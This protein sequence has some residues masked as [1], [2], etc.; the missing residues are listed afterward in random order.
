MGQTPMRAVQASALVSLRR[1]FF[2]NGQVPD[3]GL[4]APVLRSW[5]R[6]LRLGLDIGE[7]VRPSNTTRGDLM[8][9]RERN[10]ELLNHA[11]GVMEHLHEQIRASGSMVLLADAS[12]LILH[13]IGDPAFVD[14]A[15]RVALQPGASWS[16]C[17][18]GTNAIGATLIE[19]APVEVFGAEHYLDCNG[20]LT[21]SAAPILDCRGELLGALDIS[22]DHRNHQPHTLGLARM[23]VRLVERRMFESEYARHAIFAFHP[24]PEGVGGLQEGLLAVDADGEIVAADRQARALL[25]V[26]PGRS[27][28]LGGFGNLFRSSFGTV[29]G[30]AAR[31]P[32]ALMALELR[33]G[34][35]V[36]ARV[37]VSL[38]WHIGLQAAQAGGGARAART[39][40]PS[41]SARKRV[42]L[43]TLATGDAGLQFALDRCAKVVGRNIPILIQGESGSGKELLARACHNSGPRADGPFVAVNCAA[44]PEN[45]IE[46]ELFGY[47]GG[48]FTGARKEGAIGRIQQA[49]GG[50]L[51]LDEIGDMPLAMQARLLRVLQERCVQPVGAA[52]PVAVDIALLCATHRVLSDS[53]KAGCFREDLYYRVNGL[54][55][56]LPPLRERS[57]LHQIVR[58]LLDGSHHHPEPARIRIDPATMAVLEAYA[59]PGNIR[60]LQNV[61]EVALALLDEDEDCILPLHLPDEVL[62]GAEGAPVPRQ[63]ACA[64][65]VTQAEGLARGRGRRPKDID[66]AA[67]RAALERFDG[68]LSAAAR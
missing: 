16:E 2:D 54:T 63:A 35:T 48:A 11:G 28:G 8:V 21:C 57:D 68:N 59:W 12:G 55:A 24:R 62:Q 50:T 38:A 51:F 43:Q 5:E 60:Q 33:S 52:E 56:Q 32:G 44:I 19:R 67:I 22:G 41:R 23:G 3:A 40:D 58:R 27:L 7:R 64:P 36:Y 6:C 10:A 66:D 9:A 4:P 65:V 42:T 45:L 18:R 34:A 30:R 13:G 17:Q 37:R 25:G 26:E 53:V 49:H 47:V 46:S 61:L 39:P 15:S 29:I 1:Q 20:V 14:R 31:D